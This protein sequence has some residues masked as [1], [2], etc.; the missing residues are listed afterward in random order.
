MCLVEEEEF[1]ATATVAALAT[2]NRQG[3]TPGGRG[4]QGG[5]PGGGRGGQ[6]QTRG[7]GAQQRRGQAHNR[8]RGGQVHR[9]AAAPRPQPPVVQVEEAPIQISSASDTESDSYSDGDEPE[10]PGTA[11]YGGYGRCYRCNRRGHWANGCPF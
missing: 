8:G 4:G 2:A 9:N 3:G 10:T 11:Y 6:G 1:K 5:T 7:R